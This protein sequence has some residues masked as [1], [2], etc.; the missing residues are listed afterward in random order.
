MRPVVATVVTAARWEA[1]LVELSRRS[2]A[3]RIARRCRSV[4]DI[5]LVADRIDALVIGSE[6]PWLCAP[7]LDRLGTRGIAVIGVVHRADRAGRRMLESGGVAEIVDETDAPGR[8]LSAILAAPATTSGTTVAPAITVTGPRGAPG[9]SEIAL[10]L[11]WNTATRR[12]TILIELDE[13]APGLGLRLGLGP[14]PGIAPRPR[15]VGPLE[16]LTL[17]P[18][19]G[20]LS[21]S[22]ASRLI[23]TARSEFEAVVIDAGPSAHTPVG[24]AIGRGL[25]VIEPS[26]VGLVRAGLLVSTWTGPTPLVV[27]N[28]VPGGPDR[29]AAIRLT[30][31]ATG[32]EP[33]AA[34][35]HLDIDGWAPHPVM[36]ALLEPVV[37][38]VFGSDQRSA[39]R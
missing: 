24:F 21:A 34:I 17:P 6:T 15:S 7:L 27:A 18:R 25:L 35:P 2:A 9:R 29:D 32:L 4:A 10:A 37:R 28:R 20:P 5:D 13:E 16:L 26:P 19:R 38:S 1:D 23:E 22:L 31:A 8:L 30:R 33:V 11:A 39:A 14:D 12:R 36:D 3:F